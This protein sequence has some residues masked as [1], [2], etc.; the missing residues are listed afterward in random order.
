MLNKRLL[1]EK[2]INNLGRDLVVIRKD[3]RE[4]QLSAVLQPIWDKNKSNFRQTQ[5][6][7]GKNIYDYYHYIGPA[8]CDI[9]KLCEEDYIFCEGNKY[10]LIKAE[11][12]YVGKNIHFYTGILQL[13]REVDFNELN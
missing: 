3:G 5:Y 6:P 2:Y 12:I 8:S 9:T 1:C 11:P 10:C 7:I 13:I 4:E